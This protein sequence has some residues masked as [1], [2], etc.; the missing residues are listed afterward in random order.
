MGGQIPFSDCQSRLKLLEKRSLHCCRPLHKEAESSEINVLRAEEPPCK[1]Q[2]ELAPS[3]DG[4]ENAMAPREQLG[5]QA[6]IRR[7]LIS[8]APHVFSVCVLLVRV[9]EKATHM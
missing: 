7:E 5:K 3:S 9:P 1:M 8:T 4:T 6:S 2:K